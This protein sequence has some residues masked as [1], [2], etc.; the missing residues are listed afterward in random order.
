MDG[1]DE[2]HDDEQRQQSSPAGLPLLCPAFGADDETV[3]L[4]PKERA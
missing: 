3:S 1:A 2:D 4:Q